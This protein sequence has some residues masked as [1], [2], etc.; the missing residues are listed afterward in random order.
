MHIVFL[1][2]SRNITNITDVP[3]T[4]TAESTTTADE[5]ELN[6]SPNQI[7]LI[8]ILCYPLYNYYYFI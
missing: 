1:I 4:T 8:Y 3:S 2:Y 7:Y 5:L 6:K